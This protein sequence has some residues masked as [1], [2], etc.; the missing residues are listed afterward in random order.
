MDIKMKLDLLIP[1]IR[2]TVPATVV[3]VSM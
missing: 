3:C 2:S 1:L